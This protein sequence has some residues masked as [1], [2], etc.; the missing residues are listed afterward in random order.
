MSLSFS[1][2]R[3]YLFGAKS[4]NAINIITGISVF[5]ITL[6]TAALILILSVFN[7]FET[8][9]ASIFDAFNPD[10]KVE[11]IQGKQFNLEDEKI[12]KIEA[13]AGIAGV[14]KTIEEIALF[15]YNDVQ[16]IGIIKGVDENFKDVT[17]I[18]T[19]FVLG[20]YLL[21]KGSTYYGMFSFDMATKLSLNTN[22]KLSSVKIYMPLRKSVLPGAKEF[23]IKPVY[24]AAVYSLK[25]SDGYQYVLASFDLVNNLLQKKDAI[26]AL[27]IKLKDKDL[28]TETRN[29]IQAILGNNFTVKNKYEQEETYLKIINIEKWVSFLITSLTIILIVFNLIGSLWMIVLDKKKDFSILKSMGHTNADTR[30]IILMEGAIIT[31]LGIIL[32]FILATLIFIIQK[33]MGVIAVPD[34]F[35]IDAYPVRLKFWDFILVAI[36]LFEQSEWRC[37]AKSIVV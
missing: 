12:A 30:N 3:R 10:L 17:R 14:S 23:K 18:D 6:G 25:D 7:G 2:A 31:I 20:K 35:M 36:R 4:T 27:E 37:G 8:L 29:S 32:G 13:L 1:I 33:N 5:G 11:S 22:D 16:Q 21:K 19:T 9:L 24:P 34:G 26:S 15:E 28:E